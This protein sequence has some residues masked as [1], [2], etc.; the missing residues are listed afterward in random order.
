M[1]GDKIVGTNGIL[2]KWYWTKWYEQNGTDKI[3][4][5][6]LPINPVPIEIV[7][8]SSISLPL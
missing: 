5:I 3:L 8:F 1:V 7:I 4:R 2:K 6:K